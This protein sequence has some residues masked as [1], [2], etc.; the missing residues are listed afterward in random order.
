MRE[1]EFLSLLKN[2]NLT[3]RKN[4]HAIKT[5]KTKLNFVNK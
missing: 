3:A 5:K 4:F 1:F 2:F